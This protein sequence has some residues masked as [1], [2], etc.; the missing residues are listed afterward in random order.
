MSVLAPTS[1]YFLLSFQ[2]YTALISRS[3]S[4]SLSLSMRRMSTLDAE[5]V[6][7]LAAGFERAVRVALSLYQ[8]LRVG[9]S[10]PWSCTYALVSS[11]RLVVSSMAA[12]CAELLG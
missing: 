4:L 10:C 5:I 12:L 7:E 3:L 2:T 11:G 8:H 1:P 9:R 6:S